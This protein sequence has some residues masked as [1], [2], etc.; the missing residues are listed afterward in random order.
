[1]SGM[2]LADLKAISVVAGCG[3]FRKAAE[4]LGVATSSLSHQVA[5]VERRIGIRLFNRTTRSVAITE[6]GEALLERVRPALQ[7]ID[8]ALNDVERLRSVPS[9]VLRLNTSEG[10]AER[11]LPMVLD[12]LAKHAEMKVDL[13]TEG[14]L[15]DIVTEGF[16]AGLRLPDTIPR[17]MISVS[18]GQIEAFVLVASASYLKDRTEPKSPGD[19][20]RHECIGT[21]L[22]SGKLIDWE[23]SRSSEVV[24]I[25]PAGRLI[26]GSTDLGVAAARLGSGVAYAP[27]RSVENDLKAGT[28]VQLLTEWTPSYPG[29]CLYYPSRKLPSAGLRAFIDHALQWRKTSEESGATHSAL[30]SLESLPGSS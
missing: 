13:V 7:E 8:A 14:R 16:D 12:F 24:N 6:A 26:A 9:G 1:M 4:E 30:G 28:L 25:R 22:P 15:V 5:S 21:R 11:V 3:S 29:I 10:G 23:L 19:L 18:L 17:D 20:L 2:T 27:L